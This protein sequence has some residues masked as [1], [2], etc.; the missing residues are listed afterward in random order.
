MHNGGK[1]D[2]RKQER[3]RLCNLFLRNGGPN[4]NETC[5]ENPSFSLF[6]MRAG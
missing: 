6:M 1:M 5:P 2:P 4:R 3:S